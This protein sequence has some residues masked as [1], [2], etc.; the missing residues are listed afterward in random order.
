ME[1]L[2]GVNDSALYFKRSWAPRFD[3]SSRCLYPAT[4]DATGSEDTSTDYVTA[5]T[6]EAAATAATEA[7]AATH[8]AAG[9]TALPMS[10]ILATNRQKCSVAPTRPPWFRPLP[11]ST[12]ERYFAAPGQ[13][14]PYAER[15]FS[16][17]CLLR[18]HT[19]LHYDSSRTRVL[20]FSVW[21]HILVVNF[22][23]SLLLV[24][25]LLLENFESLLFCP[26]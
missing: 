23:V 11:F 26:M 6:V 19:A 21:I 7:A 9:F 4:D 16:V 24:C 22:L 12:L 13:T 15:P 25:A 10:S 1:G 8:V 17:A 3:G 14:L 18:P 5:T 2:S 20:R